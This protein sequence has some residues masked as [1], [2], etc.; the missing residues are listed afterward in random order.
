MTRERNRPSNTILLPLALQHLLHRNL[1]LRLLPPLTHSGPEKLKNSRQKNSWNQ[2]NPK[3]FFCE[4]AFLNF[5]P[6]QKLILAIFLKS[7]KMYFGQKK[8]R[9]TD[10]VFT[11]LFSQVFLART[12]LNFLAQCAFFYICY[13]SVFILYHNNFQKIDIFS[14]DYSWWKV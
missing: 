10:L 9:E 12:F 6:V 2:I 14:L 7:Q 3:Y 8:F 5:F 1:L 4:I 11:Y 13:F